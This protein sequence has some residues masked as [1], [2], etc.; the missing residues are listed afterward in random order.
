MKRQPRQTKRERKA[1]Q[2]HLR[3]DDSALAEFF[4]RAAQRGGVVLAYG[5]EA[6]V[7]AARHLHGGATVLRD[8]EENAEEIE[9][10]F[11]EQLRALAK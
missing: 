6:T 9:Q 2:R 7:A 5:D 4:A 11:S 10:L 8:T 1:I 3:G